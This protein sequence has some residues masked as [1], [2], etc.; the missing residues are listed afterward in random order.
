MQSELHGIRSHHVNVG[1]KPPRVCSLQKQVFLTIEQSLP[2][3]LLYFFNIVEK[4]TFFFTINIAQCFNFDL[5]F[6]IF[7][8]AYLFSSV[9]F[10][11]LNIIHKCF[12]VL[13]INT[14]LMGFGFKSWFRNYTW[15]P[16]LFVWSLRFWECCFLKHFRL[17]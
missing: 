5:L 12:D 14:S 10:K 13:S 1:N 6:S 16:E 3:P 15:V 7:C 11:V 9:I 17:S 8:V 2:L 4:W